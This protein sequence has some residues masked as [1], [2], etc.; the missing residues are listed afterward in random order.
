VDT[1]HSTDQ[2][3]SPP[4]PSRPRERSDRRAGTL[5]ASGR[6]ERSPLGKT[7]DEHCV[8]SGETVEWEMSEFLFS[9][10]CGSSRAGVRKSI[11]PS[12]QDCQSTPTWWLY[13]TTPIL[14]H[15][16]SRPRERSDREPGPFPHWGDTS[17]HHWERPRISATRFPG[18]RRRGKCRKPCCRPRHGRAWRIV[19]EPRAVTRAIA[20]PVGGHRVMADCRA[21]PPRSRIRDRRRG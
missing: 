1:P 13:R 9:S 20:Q 10:G 15:S 6:H 4:S 3:T 2:S 14:L 21:R 5:P 16:P 18:K 8:L 7:P 11:D 12:K 19:S 17:A